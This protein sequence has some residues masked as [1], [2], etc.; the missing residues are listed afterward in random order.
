MIYFDLEVNEKTKLIA[1]FGAIKDNNKKI[2]TNNA[3]EFK[4]FIKGARFFVGHNVISHDFEYLA[5]YHQFSDVRKKDAIDT[6]Y[7]STLLFSEEPYHSLVKDYKIYSKDLNNPLNDSMLVRTLFADILEA[8]NNLSDNLKTIYYG[9]LNNIDGFEA[10]FRFIKYRKRF[11]NLNK[12]ITDEF[13]GLVCENAKITN[14]IKKYPV[15]LSYALS[16]ISTKNRN[17]LLPPWILKNYPVVESILWNLRN[18][19]CFSCNYCKEH[20]SPTKALKKY[21]DY[22]SFRKFEG[23]SLQEEAVKSG[24]LNE[25]IITIFPTGGGKSLAFQLPALMI[26]ENVKGLTVVISPL[27]SLMKDQVDSLEAKGINS[28]VTI[29]GLLNPLERQQAIN[30]I[31]YGNASILYIAPESL[32]S[33]AILNLLL[34]RQIARFVIDEAHCFSTWGHDFRVDYQYIGDFIKLIIEEKNLKETIPVSCFTATAKKQVIF[35]IKAYFKKKLD[36]DMKVIETHGSRKNLTYEV[37]KFEDDEEKYKSLKEILTSN[38]I[39][40]IIYATTTKKVEDL[41]YRLKRESFNVSMFHGK[42]EKDEKIIEQNMFMENKS[43]IMIATN[44]FGMGVDKDNI[45]RII[46]YDISDSLENY[47]QE[48]GRAGRKEDINAICYIL[49]SDTD[50]NT[51]FRMLNNSKLNLKEIQQIWSGIKFLT[52]NRNEVTYSA[53]EIA[54]TSG[55]DEEVKDISTRV[56]TAIAALED[57]G[58]VKRSFNAPLIYAN[59]ILAKSVMEANNLIEKSKIFNED[60]I[61]IAKR[62]TKFLITEKH[63][64][65]KDGDIPEARVDYIADNLA[66]NT[67]DVVNIVRKLKESNVLKDEKDLKAEIVDNTTKIIPNRVMK[68]FKEIIEYLLAIFTEERVIYNYKNIYQQLLEK[69]IKC[70]LKDIKRAVSYLA[71]TRIVEVDK[72]NKDNAIIKLN[73]D[74]NILLEDFLKNVKVDEFIIDYVYEAKKRSL[75]KNVV[76]FSVMELVNEYNRVNQLLNIKITMKEIEERLFYLQKIEALKVE[77]GFFVIYNRLTITKKELNPRKAFTK[78]DYKKLKEYYENKKQQIHIVGEFANILSQSPTKALKFVNDYFLMNYDDFINQYFKGSEKKKLNLNM[79]LN[80]YNELFG[81]LT[82]EQLAVINDKEN[83]TIAVAAGPGSGKTKVLVHKLASI[84]YSEDIRQEQLLML[85]FSRLAATDFKEKLVELIGNTAYY[86]DIRTF[87]SYAFDVLGKV[88]NIDETTNVIKEATEKIKN[89]EVEPVKATKMILVI[90]EAQDMN[91]DEFA[92]V[93]ALIEYNE[94]L[95]VVAVG[96]DDQNIF[97]FRDADSKYFHQLAKKDEAFYELS[98]NFRSRRNLVDFSNKVVKLI[99]NRLKQKPIHAH[100]QELGYM[101]ITKYEE[102]K[103]LMP[104]VKDL[105][106]SRLNGTTAILTLRNEEALQITG[107]L[108]H[109]GKKAELIQTNER[110]KTFNVYEIRYFYNIIEEKVKITNNQI[111]E[112]I[113]IETFKNFNYKFSRVKDYEV[114]RLILNKFKETAELNPFI[115]DFK[116]YLLETNLSD[117]YKKAPFVVS[118]LHKSKGKE[119]D[120]VFIYYDQTKWLDDSDLRV[121]YV[122][123]TRAKNNLNIHINSKVLNFINEEINL[124]IVNNKETITEPETFIYSLSYGDVNLDYFYSIQNKVKRAFQGDK[125]EIEDDFL[126]QNKNKVLKLSKEGIKFV[127]KRMSLGYKIEEIEVERLVYW[128]NK[129][130]KQEYLIMFPKI[131]FIKENSMLNGVSIDIKE[132]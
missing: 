34:G 131:T 104:F 81:E 132:V 70:E 105:L 121:L 19:S 26:N 82:K 58:Y 60:E 100:K 17:S 96:D 90:D 37:I 112:N 74:K 44:A 113:W 114:Y 108:N 52:K 120:N 101:K 80:K 25:S 87:H 77:G 32:R 42:M 68:T 79:S 86:I 41:Y 54:R 111:T 55:W 9:L 38:N 99:K 62:V 14:Y 16:I 128:Y 28:A 24:L 50:L 45:K 8:F 18:K 109:L 71:R 127:K 64:N 51:H 4:N 43:E 72:Q 13:K 91:I 12:L 46:H 98:T 33:K 29:N 117:Y 83:E 10:F 84:L 61:I 129:K 125:L 11:L 102:G 92:L 75:E 110:I 53:L 30:Q 116:L 76:H 49:F 93:S 124:K 36:L 39:P 88:G 73:S 21:F 122:A 65:K 22:D 48:A 15:E 107:I 23:F 69:E 78:E 7:L 123:L 118:T 130:I 2:H 63:I 85:T 57:A 106:N 56:T 89:R 1:D 119:F 94:D 27:Q 5:N 31:K 6:L 95:R 67:E 20:L 66:L 59:S 103:F 35:D 40:T 115:D 3:E 47:I 97:E 126:T